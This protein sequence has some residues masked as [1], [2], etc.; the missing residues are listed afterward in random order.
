MLFYA[1]KITW[2]T[3]RKKAFEDS[4]KC[5]KEYREL[6]KKNYLSLYLHWLMSDDAVRGRKKNEQN[7]WVDVWKNTFLL[8]VGLQAAK[9]ILY[10]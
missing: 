4:K 3:Q 9:G 1:Q 10:K 2:T 5:G 6:H 8:P 7:E